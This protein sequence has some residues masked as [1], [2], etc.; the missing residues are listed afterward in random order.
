MFNSNVLSILWDIVELLFHHRFRVWWAPRFVPQTSIPTLHHHKSRKQW[1][2][3]KKS[4]VH[5]HTLLY[6]ACRLQDVQHWACCLWMKYGI[7]WQKLRPWVWQ[8]SLCIST[9]SCS[10][11]VGFWISQPSHSSFLRRMFMCSLF[12]H[13]SLKAHCIRENQRMKAKQSCFVSLGISCQDNLT[14]LGPWRKGNSPGMH[15]HRTWQ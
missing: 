8:G 11:R 13:N 10:L 7:I 9:L 12:F 5:T 2:I 3:C 14:W 4:N 6:S 15:S 1:R